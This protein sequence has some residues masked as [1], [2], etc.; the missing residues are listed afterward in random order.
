MGLAVDWRLVER[1]REGDRWVCTG[2]PAHVLDWI[3]S[4]VASPG[5]AQDLRVHR[6]DCDC[7]LKTQVIP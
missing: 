3:G 5:W 7:S 2:L 4:A 6:R 1:A